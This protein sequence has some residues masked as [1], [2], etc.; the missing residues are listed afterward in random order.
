MFQL[1]YDVIFPDNTRKTLKFNTGSAFIFAFEENKLDHENLDITDV[2]YF[3]KI[4]NCTNTYQ[5]Y[6]WLLDHLAA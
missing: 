4:V 5:L 3:G 2:T 6:S 1:R